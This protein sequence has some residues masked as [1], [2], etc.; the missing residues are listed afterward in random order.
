LRD[1]VKHSDISLTCS[2]T[3]DMVCCT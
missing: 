2:I 1:V 3:S